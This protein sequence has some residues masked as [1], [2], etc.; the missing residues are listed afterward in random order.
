[1]I[2][3]LR[4][5]LF[6]SAAVFWAAFALKLPPVPPLPKIKIVQV[7]QVKPIQDRIDQPETRFS[8]W[9]WRQYRM[10]GGRAQ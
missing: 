3:P 7:R 4:G 5:A 9:A 2:C 10:P 6:I 8:H 1:M